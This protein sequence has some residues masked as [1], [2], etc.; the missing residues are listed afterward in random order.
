MPLIGSLPKLAYYQRY[1]DSE[2]EMKYESR[3]RYY[4]ERSM[5]FPSRAGVACR[6]CAYTGYGEVVVGTPD[7]FRRYV[8]QTG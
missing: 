6:A 4:A 1:P 7:H 8:Q 5:R 2:L 3:F